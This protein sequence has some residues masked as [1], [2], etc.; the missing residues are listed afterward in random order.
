LDL[1]DSFFFLAEKVEPVP[2]EE[3]ALRGPADQEIL[4]SF[5]AAQASRPRIFGSGAAAN[6]VFS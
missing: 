6:P 4:A 3:K 1:V 2:E 5:R